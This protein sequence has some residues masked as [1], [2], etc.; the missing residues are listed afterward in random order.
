MSPIDQSTVRNRLLAALVPNDFTLRTRMDTSGSEGRRVLVAEDQGIVALDLA[1]LLRG[2]GCTVMGP[3]GS[4]LEV[5]KL[6]QQTQPDAALLEAKLLDGWATPVAEALVAASV[7][8]ALLTS[9]DP[10]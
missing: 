4:N 2:W 3:V 9:Y 5:L 7:P 1:Q 8:F 6:L 10:T